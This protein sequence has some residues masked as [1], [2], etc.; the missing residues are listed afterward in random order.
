V[1]V[2]INNLNLHAED[3]RASQ[4]FKFQSTDFPQML[5]EFSQLQRAQGPALVR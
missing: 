4:C 3:M 5:D 2:F 1:K